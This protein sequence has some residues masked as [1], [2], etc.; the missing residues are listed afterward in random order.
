MLKTK[1]KGKENTIKN[2]RV[3][4][5]SIQFCKLKNTIEGEEKDNLCNFLKVL[6]KERR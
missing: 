6:M 2:K 5:V 4:K 3:N 1:K